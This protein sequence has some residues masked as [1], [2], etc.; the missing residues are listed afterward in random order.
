MQ[1][2]A[3]LQRLLKERGVYVT[4]ECDRCGRILGPVR[5]TRRS[6]AGVYCCRQCR[7]GANAHAPG[8]CWTCGASLAGLRHGTKFCSDVCR[9]RENRK[10]QTAQNWR[11][12]PLK[13]ED[14]QTRMKAL[15]VVPHP[16]PVPG[17]ET[18]LSGVAGGAE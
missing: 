11:N 18:L 17:P 14:L 5:Y 12:E 7:D 10:S 16:R 3:E 15:A 8:T 2:S 6:D 1:V 13:T 4:E 9:V